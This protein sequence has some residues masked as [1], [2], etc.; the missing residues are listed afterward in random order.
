MMIR[1]S[2]RQ[3][4][5]LVSLSFIAA[6]NLQTGSGRNQRSKLFAT[7]E[8]TFGM[9]CFWKPSEELLKVDGVV[10]TIAGYT[11]KRDAIKAPTYDTVC[12]SRDWVEGVRVYY[13]DEKIS[14]DQLLDAFF[15]AQEP[16]PQSRQYSSIIFPHNEQQA[17]SAQSWLQQEK[18]RSDGVSNRI[19]SVE[20]LTRFFGAEGYHQRYW[21]KQRPRFAAI[22]VLLM[23]STGL[24]DNYF[25]V[26]MI[27]QL[28]TAF[29]F[30]TIAIGLYQIV[31]RKLDAKVSEL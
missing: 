27:S 8:A 28:H 13:D 25:P 9:G 21:Q 26:D 12:F 20:P 29:N 24:A 18:S 7:K 17:Q 22:F 30:A 6:M 5:S 10:D 16:Q 15:E 2:F 31:E 4:L 1:C 23:L 19:T 3:L 11:G 14:Y